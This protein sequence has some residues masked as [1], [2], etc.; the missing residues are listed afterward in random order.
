MAFM[1]ETENDKTLLKIS[2]VLS[3]YE[4]EAFKNELLSGFEKGNELYIDLG[5]VSDCDLTAIQLLYSAGK[6]AARF[7]KK[8]TFTN[9]PE[10]ILQTLDNACLSIEKLIKHDEKEV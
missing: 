2:G 10:S 4:A 8:L 9:I 1:T 3:I 6:S 5:S 7:R